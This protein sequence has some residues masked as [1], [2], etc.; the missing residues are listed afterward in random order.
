[1]NDLKNQREATL[2]RVELFLEK[3]PHTDQNAR[4][5]IR[6]VLH[7]LGEKILRGPEISLLEQILR[8]RPDISAW[9]MMGALNVQ[10]K[11]KAGQQRVKSIRQ[12]FNHMG[13][14]NPVT[15]R[16][17]MSAYYDAR[18]SH[19]VKSIVRQKNILNNAETRRELAHNLAFMLVRDK[20]SEQLVHP[21]LVELAGHDGFRQELGTIASQTT[22]Q[23]TFGTRDRP[24]QR[25]AA[26]N[27]HDVE[28]I[29]DVLDEA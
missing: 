26:L 18:I 12:V 7:A 5:L 11:A 2:N 17:A 24:R 16:A 23:Y 1:M 20:N 15:V 21:F 22:V 9:H 13:F 19:H 29:K 25:R 4:S 3:T 6:S 10:G 8:M 27:R 28:R 14:A